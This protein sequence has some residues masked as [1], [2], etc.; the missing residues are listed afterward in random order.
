MVAHDFILANHRAYSLS[1]LGPKTSFSRRKRRSYLSTK[2]NNDQQIEGYDTIF[3]AAGLGPK[4]FLDS[5]TIDNSFTTVSGIFP[6]DQF[7]DYL[8]QQHNVEYVE[9]NQ[10]YK[11]QALLPLWDYSLN[12]NTKSHTYH[13]RIKELKFEKRG[14][15][16]NAISPNW[17]QSRIMQR[18]L[19]DLTQYTYDEAAG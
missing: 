19:G 14:A 11:A 15:L 8:H 9:T 5:L 18:T 4:L 3:S 12:D 6:D 17:G 2:N 10:L 7:I 16:T 13:E 1:Q